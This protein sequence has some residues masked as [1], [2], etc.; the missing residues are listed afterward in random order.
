MQGSDSQCGYMLL[1]SLQE[2]KREDKNLNVL[3]PLWLERL[4]GHAAACE[5]GIA[6][7]NNPRTVCRLLLGRGGD[8]NAVAQ[9]F[10]DYP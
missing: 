7:E 10:L 2:H 9:E 3:Q 4:E 6:M 8:L 5:G 1:P